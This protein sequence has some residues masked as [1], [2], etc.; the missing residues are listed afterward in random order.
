MD[1]HGI[2]F[3]TFALCVIKGGFRGEESYTI[4]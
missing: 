1:A 2:Y 3:V 4:L